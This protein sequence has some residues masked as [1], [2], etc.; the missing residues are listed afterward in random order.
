MV[1]SAFWV[2]I[3][4]LEED[5]RLGKI[6]LGREQGVRGAI[7]RQSTYQYNSGRP[8]MV[9]TR[10]QV[11]GLSTST[12]RKRGFGEERYFYGVQISIVDC[13]K[14]FL[15]TQGVVEA[16]NPEVNQGLQQWELAVTSQK[17]MREAK[18]M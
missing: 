12:A 16:L 3:K 8:L 18:E 10:N 13:R 5:S 6:I 14:F 11:T 9:R 2:L 17:E 4:S 7:A 1:A 15:E